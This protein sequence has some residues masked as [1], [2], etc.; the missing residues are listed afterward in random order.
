[1]KRKYFLVIGLVLILLSGCELLNRVGDGVDKQKENSAKVAVVVEK[2][3]ETK[4]KFESGELTSKEF[5]ETYADLRIEL[6]LIKKDIEDQADKD[7]VSTAE[8]LLYTLGG[9]ALRGIPSKGPLAFL[10][11]LLGGLFG[12]RKIEEK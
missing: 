6:A 1:M 9:A 12:R 3:K 8:V 4:A 11:P 7:N 2:V 5:T 10:L